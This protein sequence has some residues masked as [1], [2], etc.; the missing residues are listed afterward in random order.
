MYCIKSAVNETKKYTSTFLTFM[1]QVQQS[2]STTSVRIITVV[3]VVQNERPCRTQLPAKQNSKL[4]FRGCA[5]AMLLPNLIQ[6]F[7]SLVRLKRCVWTEPYKLH[8][9]Q[10]ATYLDEVL[11]HVV[12]Y[13]HLSACEVKLFY[14]HCLILKI[15][16][17]HSFSLNL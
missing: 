7:K 2:T 14:Q 17:F 9:R 1:S 15:L 16:V 6:E 11:E 3:R 13:D 12:P 8:E 10:K 4:W 5:S